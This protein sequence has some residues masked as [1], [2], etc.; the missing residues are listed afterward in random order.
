MKLRTVT[1]VASEHN[2][3]SEF[4]EHPVMNPCS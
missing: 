1:H 4:L 3:V 2:K